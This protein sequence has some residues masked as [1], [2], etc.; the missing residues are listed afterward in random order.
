MIN[1]TSKFIYAIYALSFLAENSP[2]TLR[3]KTIAQ[4]KHIPQKFLAQILNK[5]ANAGIVKNTRGVN[6][7][8]K[9][10]I[11]PEKISLL[12][13]LETLEGKISFC[14]NIKKNTALYT[15]FNDAEKMVK[16][17]LSISVAELIEKQKKINSQIIYYI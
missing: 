4:E 1:F 16:K 8:C 12:L 5:L 17:T 3:I 6:G 13:I 2:E 10:N 9:L 14:N 7:G 11:P 15:V